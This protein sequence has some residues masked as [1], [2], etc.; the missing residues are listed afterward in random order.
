DAGGTA[1]S[2]CALRSAPALCREAWSTPDAPAT[3]CRPSPSRH[4]ASADH[5]ANR[6]Q[7]DRRSLQEDRR[8]VLRDPEIVAEFAD[9]RHQVSAQRQLQQQAREISA[10][11]N[12]Q[13]DAA[14]E[15]WVDLEDRGGVAAHPALA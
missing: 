6:W 4:L 15:P 14:R 13:G 3:R 11:R 9:A 2:A 10:G 1:R 8:L 7:L 5:F 12:R